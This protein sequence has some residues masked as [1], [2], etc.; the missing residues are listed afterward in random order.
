MSATFPE[1]LG[2]SGNTYTDDKDPVTGLAGGGH[3][4]LWIPMLLDIIAMAETASNKAG[5]AASSAT[6]A[7]EKA[8]QTTEDRNVVA[9]D[10]T[11]VQTLRNE[12]GSFRDQASASA[13][14]AIQKAA[15]TDADRIAAAS[16]ETAAANSAASAAVD[17][18]RAEDAAE[19]LLGRRTV[20][21]LADGYQVVGDA[22]SGTHYRC[23]GTDLSELELSP[24]ALL[25]ATVHAQARG[26]G[27]VGFYVRSGS[28][29][30]RGGL[31]HI[32]ERDG[33]VTATKTAANEWSIAGDLGAVQTQ[34][35]QLFALDGDGFFLLSG[36]PLEIT[37]TVAA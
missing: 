24:D 4:D 31:R 34:T 23:T 27:L 20:V 1:N 29:R 30:G 28:L 3:R 19:G 21:D 16:S 15:E 11:A 32:T 9:D 6:T 22:Q 14:T 18:Q 7:S 26:P 5:Q 37:R 33:Q 8:A 13:N 10:R 17:A 35:E 25:G 12:A 36:A 2:G